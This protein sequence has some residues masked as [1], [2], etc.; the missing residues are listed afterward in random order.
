MNINSLTIRDNT[1]PNGAG[2][3]ATAGTINVR[4]STL[5]AN[6][7]TTAGG[8]VGAAGGTVKLGLTTVTENQAPEGAGCM[9]A[10]GTTT[11]T[12]SI[13]AR[14]KTGSTTPRAAT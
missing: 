1:A 2:L 3:Y 4:N 7:A 5:S 14:N 9:L 8:G 6:T 12:S 11:P 10:R 13:I